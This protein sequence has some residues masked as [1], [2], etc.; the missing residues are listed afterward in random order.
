[1]GTFEVIKENHTPSGMPAEDYWS[2]CFTWEELKVL[3][4]SMR[5][6]GWRVRVVPVEEAESEGRIH[7]YP[8]TYGVNHDVRMVSLAGMRLVLARHSLPTPKSDPTSKP[9]GY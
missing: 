9:L 3:V 6:L 4:P 7:I 5:R 8:F 1:M 2:E